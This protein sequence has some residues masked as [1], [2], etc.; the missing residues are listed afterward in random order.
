[1]A[2][3]MFLK[4][5]NDI[6]GESQDAKHKDEIDVLAWS[7][8]VSQSGSFH[9]GGGGG[10]GKA[11][12]QDISVTKYVDKASNGLL[13][14]CSTGEALSTADLVVRKAG[15]K[16]LEYITIKMKNVLVTS[17]STGGSGGEDQ[18]TE[19]VS[20]NFAEVEYTYTDQ[21]PDG[22]AGSPMPFKF[23]IAKNEFKG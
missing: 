5:S 9:S 13:R 21:K 11:A 6:K 22:N 18:L 14:A 8:G 10:T 16:P 17:V 23:D 15:K 7:W 12:F 3:D 20:L 19:N 4:L 2:V 1:M